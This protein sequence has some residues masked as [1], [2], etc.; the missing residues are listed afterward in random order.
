MNGLITERNQLTF[1]EDASTDESNCDLLKDGSRRRRLGLAAEA[2]G[3]L[4]TET[5]STTDTVFS[6]NKWENVAEQTG[7]EFVVVQMGNLVWF[8]KQGTA[9]LSGGRVDTTFTSGVEYQ[10]DLNTYQRPSASS[11]GPSAVPIQC[12]S[13]KGALVVTSPEINSIYI[14]RNVTTGAFTVTEIAFRARDYKWLGDRATYRDAVA[15]NSVTLGRSYDTRNCGWAAGGGSGSSSSSTA[16]ASFTAALLGGTVIGAAL[17][18]NNAGGG[19]NALETYINAEGDFPALTHPWFSGKNSSGVFSVTEWKKVASGT[20]F[21]TNGTYILDLYDRDRS[22]ASGISASDPADQAALEAELNTTEDA[23]FATCAAYAGR[24]F[25]SGM[26]NSTDD[27]GTK[28]YFTQVLEDGFGLI[29][30]CFQQNDPTSEF[31]SDLLD[32]DGGY[33]NIP[34]AHNIRKLHTFGPDLYVFAENG[35]WRIGGVDDVFRATEYSVNKI[36]EDGIVTA[37]SFISANGKPYWWSNSGIFTIGID[38]STGGIISQNMSVSTIQTFWDNI[39]AEERSRVQGSYDDV[40]RRVFWAY[41]SSGEASENKLNEILI[42]DEILGAFFPWSISDQDTDT[43]YMVGLA[44]SNGSG[45]TTITYNVVDSSGNQIVDSSLNDVVI[46]REGQSLSSAL[47]KVVYRD[48]TTGAIG[49]AEFSGTDF[50]DW[51]DAAYTSYAETAYNFLG[52]GMTKKNVPY[53]LTFMKTTETGWEANQ[54]GDGYDPLRP[55]SLFLKSKWDFRETPNTGRQQCYRLKYP[56]S[57]DTSELGT[58]AYPEEVVTS[59]LKIRGRGRVVVLRWESE[60]G[61]DFHLLGWSMLGAMNDR[62]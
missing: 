44:F 18:Q 58:W 52:A 40:K 47:L 21:I 27:N 22:A 19:D 41:P 9:A 60:S 56:V 33:V 7:V 57:V 20:S 32:T 53:I 3:S 17:E 43:D 62:I 35:V 51:G 42:W 12:T 36:G 24:V 23:R 29:G 14:T 10:L 49:F 55:S 26:L 6:V 13:I 1:P 48:G 38:Q 16:L 31:L 50:L 25:Y 8:Y 37:N 28:V 2:G 34:E 59:R 15:K 54:A 30:E 61:Y 5:S 45:T 46:Q 11:L 39:G 4:S